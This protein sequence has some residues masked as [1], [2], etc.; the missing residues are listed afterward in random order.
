MAY[1]HRVVHCLDAGD[2]TASYGA[3][4]G[5]SN[6]DKRSHS[7]SSNHDQ[8]DND[9][10]DKGEAS[11][12]ASPIK[13]VIILIGENR[14]LDHTFGVYRPKAAGQTI[15]NLLSKGIVNED[16][17]PGPNFAQAQQ[18]SVGAQPNFYIGA[19]NNAKF[20]YSATNAMPQP[21]TAGTPTTS[22]DTAPPFKTLAEASVEEDMD[23]GDLDILTT[24]ASSLPV[25]S[26]D[27]RVPGAGTLTGP[28][29]LQG[30]NISDDDYTGD[31]T[32][33]FFQAWQQQD[34]SIANATKDNPAG[35]KSDI[36]P[37]VMATY[38]A[39][40]KSQGN[41]MG[42]YNAEQEQAPV[43]KSL[44]DRFTL[45]DNFHQ[46][47]QGGTGANH[48]MLGTGD[49][50]FWSDG[51][52]NAI[53]PPA[54]VAIANP[55]PKAGTVNQYTVDGNFSACADVF[56]PGVQPIV[57]YLEHLPYAAEPNCK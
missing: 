10:D 26:L 15:S 4:W 12:T 49:A 45:S 33:R 40:N 28:F 3:E 31:T 50:G 57:S 23:P 44:A 16:G 25:N 6:W 34:C 46:S 7:H 41:S 17:T 8:H 22:S 24:G 37:F 48:F 51:N 27:T 19:P 42:F 35:C 47:F 2:R 39:T 5:R 55:N 29:P 38:S 53:A 32:H 20:A 13:H 43:L 9:G 36:F 52:G 1:H 11:K 56:Q 18:F 54:N 30:P 21:N 14:G